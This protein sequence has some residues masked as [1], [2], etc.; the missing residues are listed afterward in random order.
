MSNLENSKIDILEEQIGKLKKEEEKRH[1]NISRFC[2][3]I[4][5]LKCQIKNIVDIVGGFSIEYEHSNGALCKLFF[6][7]SDTKELFINWVVKNHTI[8]SYYVEKNK[9]EESEKKY[10]FRCECAEILANLANIDFLAETI[11][12]KIR[13]CI[14]S[15]YVLS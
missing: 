4:K 13:K 7:Y 5:E 8:F 3:A 10:K 12:E 11:A 14:D 2:Y 6:D 1:K 9:L 15:K